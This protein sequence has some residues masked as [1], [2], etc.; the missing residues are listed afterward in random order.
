MESPS[1]RGQDH[2][3]GDLPDFPHHRGRHT[4]SVIV[5]RVTSRE[6][7]GAWVPASRALAGRIL[8][9]TQRT[10]FPGLAPISVHE[11][12][13]LG[14]GRRIRASKNHARTARGRGHRLGDARSR[15]GIANSLGI[16]R[17]QEDLTL[18]GIAEADRFMSLRTETVPG[19]RTHLSELD[20][21]T[22]NGVLP[23]LVHERHLRCAR[24][25]ARQKEQATPPQGSRGRWDGVQARV[26]A[27]PTSNRQPSPRRTI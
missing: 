9:V 7:I 14:R 12:G 19:L 6:P 17:T 11:R 4:T 21:A 15:S 20:R 2:H 3:P 26:A 22:A 18:T 8:D 24:E 10:G 5:T 16:P 13:R 23:G 1:T 27:R 25:P